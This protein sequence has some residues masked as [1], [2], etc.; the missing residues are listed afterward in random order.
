MGNFL[1]RASRLTFI[2]SSKVFFN[3]NASNLEHWFKMKL[4]A[5]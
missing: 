3:S 4:W 1:T 2:D 5:Q